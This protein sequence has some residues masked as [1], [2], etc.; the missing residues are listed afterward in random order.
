[1][2][3][4]TQAEQQQLVQ[5]LINRGVMPNR[6]CSECGRPNSFMHADSLWAVQGVHTGPAGPAVD[7]TN[8]LIVFTLF[9]TNCG[10]AR[11]FSTTVLGV[12]GDG[13]QQT[14][15]TQSGGGGGPIG[16]APIGSAPIGG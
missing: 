14:A 5:E 4:L 3:Q 10:F 6:Q 2:A 7:P 9:C 16:S 13:S 8:A 12:V 15:D 1:M 11:S